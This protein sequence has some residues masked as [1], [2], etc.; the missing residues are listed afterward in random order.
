MSCLCRQSMQIGIVPV[1][2]SQYKLWHRGVSYHGLLK[3][4]NSDAV[5]SL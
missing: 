3:T 4:T 5:P 1:E 2:G